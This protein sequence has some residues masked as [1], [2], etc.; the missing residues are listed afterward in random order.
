MHDRHQ[1]EPGCSSPCEVDVEFIAAMETC[2][3][4]STSPAERVSFRNCLTSCSA[5]SELTAYSCWTAL[6]K[7]AKAFGDSSVSQIWDP[8]AL[9]LYVE[10]R[11]PTLP[12]T[13]TIRVSPAM[14]RE[15]TAC[16]RT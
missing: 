6:I 16:D 1:R 9:K 14:R 7:S 5:C 11:S 13:G 3:R 4:T 15:T 12:R 10:A 2:S 8:G